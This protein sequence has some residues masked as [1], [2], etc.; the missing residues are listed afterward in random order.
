[1]TVSVVRNTVGKHVH[2]IPQI[3]DNTLKKV[4]EENNKLLLDENSRNK[5]H[6]IERD[7]KLVSS[8]SRQY[9]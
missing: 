9:D 6:R 7:L 1:M 8:L 4:I 5:T 3:V 2:F